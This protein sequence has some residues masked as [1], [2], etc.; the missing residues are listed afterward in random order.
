MVLPL[1][2]SVLHVWSAIEALFPEVSTEVTFRTALYLAQLIQSGSARLEVYERVRASY[3][4]RSA[5]T[6]GSQQNVS[7]DHWS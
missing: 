6:H 5:I 1:G 7:A 2:Q 3:K 4:L